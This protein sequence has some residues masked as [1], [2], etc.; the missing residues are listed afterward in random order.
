MN[1]DLETT[2][3][4]ITP[5]AASSA[6]FHEGT[7]GPPRG[8]R[9]AA[10]IRWVLVTCMAGAAGLSVFS[11]LHVDSVH[12]EEALY[13]CPMHPEIRSAVPGRCPI[14]GMD[15]VARKRPG[16]SA[17]ASVPSDPASG[18]AKTEGVSEPPLATTATVASSPR[19]PKAAAYSCPMHPEVT[20]DHPGSCP[21]CGMFLTPTAPAPSSAKVS[22]TKPK[23]KL[24]LPTMDR[25]P[26][27]LSMDRAQLLGVRSRPVERKKMASEVRASGT[28]EIA[29]DLAYRVDARFEGWVEELTV[30]RAGERVERGQ[31][32]VGIFSPELLAAQE[33]L[34]AARHHNSPELLEAAR[35]RLDFSGV[36]PEEIKRIEAQGKASR[37]IPVRA[38]AS[39]IVLEKRVALGQRI[40]RGARL[41]DIADL[42]RLYA[43]FDVPES[44]ADAL[45]V[46]SVGRVSFPTRGRGEV[47]GRVIRVG[48]RA[49]RS[50][51]TLPATIELD[52]SSGT[53]IPGLSVRV[54]VR[55]REVEALVVD[56]ESVLTTGED[57]YVFVDEGHGR[58]SA[59]R[60]LIG[61]RSGPS[62]EIE[63]LSE[64]TLVVTTGA[65]LLDSESRLE[66][67]SGGNG[68]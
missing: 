16:S 7:E 23:A 63:G 59:R 58:Y 11:S 10:V 4:P 47:A 50:A 29:E 31:T 15:L 41:F 32:L 43:V 44:E 52:N 53:L 18:P 12:A 8:A 30:S 39:G 64:G 51:R 60:V 40:E 13:S 66:S 19:D 48:P 68:R 55:G 38:P 28:L 35:R 21:I 26:L 5:S 34:L 42:S 36:A 3:S 27:M 17:P 45:Q 20:S 2:S 49:D 14:C 46:G 6:E 54:Q 24:A 67:L 57:S 65:F 56:R 1:P 62:V 9:A 33:E 22:K 61:R 37:I 25:A